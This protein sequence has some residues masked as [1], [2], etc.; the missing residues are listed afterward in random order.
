MTIAEL[1]HVGLRVD[2][3]E[4]MHGRAAREEQR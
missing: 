1:G 2:D 4:P 3:P